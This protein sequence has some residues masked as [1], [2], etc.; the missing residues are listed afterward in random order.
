MLTKPTDWDEYYAK[1]ASTARFTRKISERKIIN[2]M[3]TYCRTEHPEIAEL[4]GANSCFVDAVCEQME[5]QTYVA[6]DNNAYGIGL[7]NQRFENSSL[8]TGQ[9]QDALE[10]SSPERRFDIVYSVG[11]IEHFNLENTARCTQS[12][13]ELCKPGGIVLITFPTPTLLY[14]VLRGVIELAGQWKFHDE[15]PLGF[16]EVQAAA[17]DYGDLVHSSINWLI[18]LTQG[19]LVYR[20]VDA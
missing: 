6:I 8:V 7:L 10:I 17:R 12:H 1:P 16:N 14:R 19:Y 5:P 3:R 4:G 9:L 2:L 18:G 13:F 11:L 15:R 20:K